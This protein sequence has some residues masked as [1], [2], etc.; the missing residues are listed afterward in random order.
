MFGLSR[1]ER[2]HLCQ[3]GQR[4]CEREAIFRE[5]CWDP[6][7]GRCHLPSVGVTPSATFVA[8]SA[9][10][11]IRASTVSRFG[12]RGPALPAICVLTALRLG[13]SDLVPAKAE[14]G[15]SGNDSASAA[16]DPPG[17]HS[18]ELAAGRSRAQHSQK[19]FIRDRLLAEYL[20]HRGLA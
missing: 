8:R 17:P 12:P 14:H 13:R 15:Q 18:D 16:L 4:R 5:T 6:R 9:W 11:D 1:H 19:D 7:R 2:S 20:P 10:A 3:D